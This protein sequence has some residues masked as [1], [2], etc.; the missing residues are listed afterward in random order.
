MFDFL[1]ARGTRRTW[2]A[3]RL[4]VSRNFLSMVEHGRKRFPPA[5][6][7]RAAEILGVPEHLLFRPEEE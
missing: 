5:R 4:G 7:A 1:E 2:F 3:E 6:R